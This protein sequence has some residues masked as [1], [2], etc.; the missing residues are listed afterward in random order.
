MAHVPVL[1]KEVVDY[2]NCRPD[3]VY[4]DCTI[5]EGGH[6]KAILEAMGSR[7]KLIGIDKDEEA[8]ERARESLKQFGNSLFFV[9]DN[10]E[11]IGSILKGLGIEKVDGILFDLGVSSLQLENPSRGFSFRLNGPLDMRMNRRGPTKASDLVNNLP[12]E[13]LKRLLRKYGEEPWAGRI[14]SLIEDSRKRR[15]ILPT[16]ELADIVHRSIPSAFQRRIDLATKTFQALRMVVNRELESLEKG[17]MES[18]FLLKAGGRI[19][20]ISYHSLEDRVVKECFRRLA[21]EEQILT[22]V[23]KKP[24][25]PSQEERERN[26]RSRSAKLRVAER[27]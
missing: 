10:F 25:I 26:P 27:L 5:G 24:L 15:P 6:A 17:L 13:G 7:S 20:S 23:T 19:C 11:R 1:L 8:I 2:L 18:A 3:K 9:H 4:V 12:R 22:S 21:K 14:A 16:G